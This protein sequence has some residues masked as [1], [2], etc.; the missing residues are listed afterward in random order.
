MFLGARKEGRINRS[1]LGARGPC[2]TNLREAYWRCSGWCSGS[3][4]REFFQDA[5]GPG[6][7]SFLADVDP[8][9]GPGDWLANI[10]DF[11]SLSL[12]IHFAI[13]RA[14]T[15]SKAWI[16]HNS[17]P[18]GM[19]GKAR[20]DVHPPHQSACTNTWSL[21]VAHW[22]SVLVYFCW[23]TV[24]CRIF[25]RPTIPSYNLACL[26]GW[27]PNCFARK[28]E[29]EAWHAIERRAKTGTCHLFTGYILAAREPQ[30]LLH[31]NPFR[32]VKSR[33]PHSPHP[34]ARIAAK[35]TGRGNVVRAFMPPPGGTLHV[36]S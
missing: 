1:Q 15:I 9:F 7:T 34:E 17:G 18:S 31:L 16:V 26:Q 23:A 24:S 21:L 28:T 14:W 12:S 25:G 5:S 11:W 4:L 29:A 6:N 30:D 27:S 32:W 13:M 19:W 8:C 35:V 10:E 33:R 2:C 36:R 3:D 20:L 22:C